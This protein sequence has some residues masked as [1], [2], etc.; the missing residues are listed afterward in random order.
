MI[1]DVA[2]IER[3]AWKL[4]WRSHGSEAERNIDDPSETAIK[5]M[6]LEIAK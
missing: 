6:S 5:E 4:S 2:F 1:V 3:A